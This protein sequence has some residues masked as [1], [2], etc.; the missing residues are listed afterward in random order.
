[1]TNRAENY[2]EPERV[3]ID[4]R[5]PNIRGIVGS[6]MHTG[7]EADREDFAQ[8]M[9]DGLTFDDAIDRM[10]A[11]ISLRL[12]EATGKASDRRV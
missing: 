4:S 3:D 12:S 1:M 5:D 6:V 2:Y 10:A 11:K 9:A 7:T 8:M